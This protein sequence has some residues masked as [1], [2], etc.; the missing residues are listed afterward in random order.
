M[1]SAQGIRAGRAFVELFADDN[2]LVRGL[3]RAEKKLQDFGKSVR[4]LGLKMAGLGTALAAPMIASGKVFGDFESRM[5]MVSTMLDKPEKHMDAF[6][7]GVRKLSVELGESTD[8]LAKGLYDVLSASVNPAKALDVLKVATRAAKGGMTDTAVAVDGLTSVLNAFQLSADQAGHVADV[9]FQT[10]KRGKL[11]FPDLASNI[12]KVA[13]MA[14]AAGMS[15]E[16]MMAAIATMTRQGLSVEDS[17]TRLVN[18]LKNAPE[19]AGNLAALVQ[20]Y[21]GRS[22]S[23]IQLDFPEIRA[24]SGI[25]ALSADMEGFRKDLELMQSAA[26]QADEAFARMT[27]GLSGELKKARMA[28]TDLMVSVG[29]ALA[30]TL[31]AAGEWFKRV[32]VAAG[33]W[34]KQNRQ[35]IVTGFKV[36]V[37]VVAV[38]G[39]LVALGTIISSL[40]TAL[41]VP[42][43]ALSALAAAVAFL[44]TPAGLVIAAVTAL[45]AALLYETGAGGK[46]LAWLGDRFMALKEDALS[47]FGGVADALAAGDIALAAKILWLSLKMEWTRGIAFLEKAWLDFRNF[48]IRIGYDAWHGL[49]ASAEI[50]WHALEVG[51]IETTAF[52]SKLWSGF[53]G[54]FAKTWES[55]K[56]GA[57]K[58]WN[59]IRSLFDDSVDLAVENQLVEREKQAAIARIDDEQRQ[60]IARHQARRQSADQHHEATLAVI[61][62]ENFDL[63]GDLDQEYA[64]RI[65]ENEREFAEARQA[66]REAIDEAKEKRESTEAEES[67]GNAEKPDDIVDRALGALSGLGDIGQLIHDQAAS[68]GVAGTFSAHAAFGLGVGSSVDER[69]AK[70]SEE[71]AKN[72]RRLLDAVREGGMEFA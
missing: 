16:D 14:R 6:S 47:A 28:V 38:G 63:H 41:G 58:A 2:K 48:F 26:G 39:A 60:N 4:N 49:M 9:M 40:G 61:G 18:I 33:D 66:W 31:K 15:M 54:F 7:R 64:R 3:R 43:V 13:P 1:A 20:G 27:G 29:Q 51:W 69:T 56:A 35:A 36:A 67:V 5:K 68:I 22:L 32:V 45:G 23:G 21:V 46:A 11:T 37:A 55:I 53:A 24:A 12:G 52:F 59:W 72:T 8:V 44:V 50:V 71:T 25:A 65:A 70:A 30:P 19:Q 57:T 34:V 17:T 42:V 10:I 62:R